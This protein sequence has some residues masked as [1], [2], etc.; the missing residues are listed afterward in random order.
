MYSSFS[1]GTPSSKSFS[2]FSIHDQFSGRP[3]SV[4]VTSI[5]G[6]NNNTLVLGIEIYYILLYDITHIFTD[7]CINLPKRII[8]R[9]GR[10]VTVYIRHF[11]FY[12]RQTISFFHNFECIM[13]VNLN[14][15]RLWIEQTLLFVMQAILRKCD[16]MTCMHEHQG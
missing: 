10:I 13:A 14:E 15:H 5:S 9:V 1:I 3:S 4:L 7:I 2:Q 8:F 11:V 16:A 6:R 12:S